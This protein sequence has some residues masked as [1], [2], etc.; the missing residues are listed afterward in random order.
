ML[1]TGRPVCL[2]GGATLL[3]AANFPQPFVRPDAVR[4]FI[5]PVRLQRV[6]ADSRDALEVERPRAI[7]RGRSAMCP[8]EE[9]R[10]AGAAGAG[11]GAPELLERIVRFMA[12]VPEDDERVAKCLP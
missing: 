4:V 6:V 12:V 3:A 2:S 1:F 5:G 9:I 8:A 10:L 11:T 7:S